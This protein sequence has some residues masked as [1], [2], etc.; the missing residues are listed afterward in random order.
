MYVLEKYVCTRFWVIYYQLKN[1]FILR[2]KK[3][4]LPVMTSLDSD[5]LPLLKNGVGKILRGINPSFLVFRA[6][7]EVVNT[8][9]RVTKMPPHLLL[10]ALLTSFGVIVLESVPK[11]KLHLPLSNRPSQIVL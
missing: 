8:C 2:R 10:V 6:H 1:K 4:D 9:W 7:C 5:A 3:S 11:K